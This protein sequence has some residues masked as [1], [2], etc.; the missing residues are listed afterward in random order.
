MFHKMGGRYD[1]LDQGVLIAL[2][3]ERPD[4]VSTIPARHMARTTPC[5]SPL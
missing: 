2:L 3:S 4:I 1:N 5:R